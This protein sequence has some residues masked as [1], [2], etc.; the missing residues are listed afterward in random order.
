[1]FIELPV[2]SMSP[3]VE[4][5]WVTPSLAWEMVGYGASIQE[6]WDRYI[7]VAKQVDYIASWMREVGLE[8]AFLVGHDLGGGVAQILAVRQPELVRGLI[9]TNSICYD[10]W[11][12]PSVKAMGQW[13]LRWSGYPTASSVRSIA[14]S[15]TEAT[16]TVSGRRTR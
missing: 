4:L 13:V 6:G 8:S 3:S 14:P 15:C 2:T 12:M 11:P 5:Y 7:S 10:S 16:T 9:L 1:M